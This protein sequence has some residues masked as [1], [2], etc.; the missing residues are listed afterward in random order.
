MAGALGAASCAFVGSGQMNSFHEISR[1][2]EVRHTF[3]PDASLKDLYAELF[4]S[5]KQVYRGLKKA[6]LRANLDRFKQN[7]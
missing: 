2:V 3:Y 1:F 5:Y 6:Y 7:I 4:E